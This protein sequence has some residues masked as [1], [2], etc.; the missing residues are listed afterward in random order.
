MTI[1]LLTTFALAYFSWRFVEKPFRNHKFLTQQKVFTISLSGLVFFSLV[2]LHIHFSGGKYD[3]FSEPNPAVSGGD[4][5]HDGFYKFSANTYANCQSSKINDAADLWRGSVRCEQSSVSAPAVAIFGDS[6][7]GHLFSGLDTATTLEYVCL[8]RSG[9]PFLVEQTHDCLIDYIREEDDIEGVVY[10]AYWSEL[11]R[12]HGAKVFSQRVSA[13]IKKLRSNG[14]FVVVVAD[15]PDFQF[16]ADGCAS[17]RKFN[18]IKNR[19]TISV[20]DMRIQSTY[21]PYLQDVAETNESE[22]INPGAA[23]CGELGSSM[24]Q[25]G[26]ILYRDNDHLN[27]EGS[28]LLAI[29]IAEKSEVLEAGE[30]QGLSRSF[31]RP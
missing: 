28:L 14:K 2:G 15:V 19:C 6:H 5:S 29:Y 10:V 17:F 27:V 4:V 3:V 12:R 21:V 11:F 7:A 24:I 1:L 26:S 23:F 16:D 9:S 30:S 22:F 18:K 8:A 20:D 31:A 25:K 13:T